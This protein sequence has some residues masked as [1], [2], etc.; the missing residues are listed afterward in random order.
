[1]YNRGL[2]FD[3]GKYLSRVLMAVVVIVIFFIAKQSI[4][5]SSCDCVRYMTPCASVNSNTTHSWEKP[6]PSDGLRYVTSSVSINS[7][8]GLSGNKPRPSDGLRYVTPSVSIN[9]NTA[10]SVDKLRDKEVFILPISKWHVVFSF[11]CHWLF[12]WCTGWHQ[13]MHGV[14]T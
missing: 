11:E 8:T 13:A 10:F 5:T 9:S 7:N 14:R 6:I 12:W 1:M 2:L 3:A 4:L